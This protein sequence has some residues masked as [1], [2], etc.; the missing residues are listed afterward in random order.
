MGYWTFLIEGKNW[1][2]EINLTFFIN[3]IFIF[4][5]EKLEIS[6]PPRSSITDKMALGSHHPLEE[7]RRT[8]ANVMV[9]LFC[10]L[11]GVYAVIFDWICFSIHTPARVFKLVFCTSCSPGSLSTNHW[12]ILPLSNLCTILLY[13]YI[14]Y[15]YNELDILNIGMKL[16][17]LMYEFILSAFPVCPWVNTH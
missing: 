14:V 10:E 13:E 12:S 16:K 9:M 7:V 4:Q 6:A 3:E 17:V 8:H 1:E 5:I 11:A 2:K 15:I